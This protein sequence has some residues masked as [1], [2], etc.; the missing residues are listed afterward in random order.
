MAVREASQTMPAIAFMVAA[1][2][3]GASTIHCIANIINGSIIDY[4]FDI[5]SKTFKAGITLGTDGF[6][7]SDTRERL[8]RFFEVD[9]PMVVLA[10]LTALLKQGAVSKETVAKAIKDLGIDPEKA[11]PICV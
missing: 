10:T 5:P 2:Y 3:D 4:P 8:R 11:H 7:R 9:T 6:G 1:A